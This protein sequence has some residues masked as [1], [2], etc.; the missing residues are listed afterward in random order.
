M[1]D[2]DS[3]PF[4]IRNE[5]QLILRELAIEYRIP[6]ECAEDVSPDCLIILER[7]HAGSIPVFVNI[8][9]RFLHLR[10]SNFPVVF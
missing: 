3:F 8:V 9:A 5:A 2:N 1:K 6:Q 4:A 10:A 7:S